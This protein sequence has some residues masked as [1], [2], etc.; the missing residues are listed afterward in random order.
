MTEKI[1]PNTPRPRPLSPHLSAYNM[2]HF[3]SLTS[4]MH[5]ATGTFLLG[6]AVVFVFWLVAIAAQPGCYDCFTGWLRGF[7]G[8]VFITAWVAALSYHACNGIRHL[9]WDAG[10]GFSLPVAKRTAGLVFVG[11]AVVTLLLLI[12]IFSK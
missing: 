4:I 10:F 11:T 3:T 6:G 12:A 1:T 7:L 9:A 8:K 2:F 5:R